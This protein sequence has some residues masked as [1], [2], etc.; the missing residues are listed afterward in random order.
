MTTFDPGQN[1]KAPQ[2]QQCGEYLAI[3]D[4]NLSDGFSGMARKSSFTTE[5][6]SYIWSKLNYISLSAITETIMALSLFFSGIAQ[7]LMGAAIVIIPLV[8]GSPI[9]KHL[10]SFLV[11][12]P[13]I[14]A[15]FLPFKKLSITILAILITIRIFDYNITNP[16]FEDDFMNNMF[17]M[18]LFLLLVF[19]ISA[20]LKK[21]SPSDNKMDTLFNRR[22][23][24]V[25]IYCKTEKKHKEFPFSELIPSSKSWSTPMHHSIDP[26]QTL[27]IV[28]KE[29]G[30]RACK[31]IVNNGNYYDPYLRWE[32]FQQFMD[33]TLP[34]PDIPEFEPV[35][36]Y[37]PVTRK[38]DQ[39]TSRPPNFFRD[40]GRA[41]S[42]VRCKKAKEAADDYPWGMPLEQAKAMGWQPSIKRISPQEIIGERHV[43]EPYIRN[44]TCKV[45]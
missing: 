18:S 33:P 27:T 37:D 1:I 4:D 5:K 2:S 9:E 31:I 42:I 40:M 29:T 28:H 30:L 17:Y 15:I 23:G 13:L 26:G 43:S 11:A 25:H 44:H 45:L 32:I 22:T 36:Q 41:E 10:P 16:F 6:D 7:S 24:N 8:D 39:D 34:L 35:R 20:A 21:A 19:I 38:Y 3:F 14:T 12:I